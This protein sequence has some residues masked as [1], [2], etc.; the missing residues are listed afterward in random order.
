MDYYVTNLQGD[1][2]A[3]LDS[4]GAAVV[5]YTYDAW[6]RPLTTTGSMAPTLGQYNP[7]RYRGYVY[8][9]ET[10]LYYLQS[11]YY[12]PEWGRFIN[13]D[14]QLNPQLGLLGFNA[15]AYC[16]NNPINYSDYSGNSATIAGGIIGGVC[17]FFGALFYELGDDN[18]GVRWGKVMQCTASTALAGAMAGFVADVSIATFG[19]GTAMLIAAGA[20]VLASGVNSMYT[21]TVLSGDFSWGK[22]ISDGII[23]GITNGLCTGTS[24]VLD[25]IVSGLSEG[26]GYAFTQ[27]CAELTPGLLDITS[28][29][30]ID[31]IPTAITGVAG[32][33]AGYGYDY[34]TR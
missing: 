1:V 3:I 26:I 12:N 17:G 10:G 31:L 15:F 25:P 28:F 22:V 5:E 18:D 14:S 9:R 20:G 6:G 7:L 23:G 8:D 30:V 13:S 34:L 11:R 32:F 29:V 24:S 21:Q 19:A 2:V 16:S 27:V 4:T 33:I